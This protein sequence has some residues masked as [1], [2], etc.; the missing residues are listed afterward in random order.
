ML[1]PSDQTVACMQGTFHS[2]EAYWIASN[3]RGLPQWPLVLM[4]AV[5]IPVDE[6]C[7]AGKLTLVLTVPLAVGCCVVQVSVMLVATCATSGCSVQ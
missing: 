7:P 5:V 2:A 1:S 6:S 4:D 3:H